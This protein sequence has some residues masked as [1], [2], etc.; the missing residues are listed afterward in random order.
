MTVGDGR[1]GAVARRTRELLPLLPFLTVVVIFLLIP[2]V[3]VVVGSVYADGVFSLQRIEAL[4]SG[5]A[6][7]AL[8]DSVL[9][10]GATALLG[11]VF[12]AVLAWLIVNS[13]ATSMVRRAVLSLCSV[14]AQF[15]GVALAF[16]FLATAGINGVLTLWVQQLFGWN[17]AGSGWLYGLGGLIL[18]YTYF[19]IPLMVIVFIPALEGL[20]AQWREAA[21]SL[22]A[23]TWAYWR[24]V[25][26]P[27]LTPAFLGSAL[28]L[29]AN[30]FAAYATAAALVSQ[31]SPIVPLLIRASLVSEV[32]LGQEG[33]AYALALE[34]IVVV[35]LV[36]GAYN[37]LVR[38]SARWL[39]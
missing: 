6:L 23:S 32:V 17:M 36:M 39:S 31:G 22:G 5:T 29:F 37:L 20:R 1:S 2:T 16:A 30:A 26:I 35:A 9:L 8:A 7:A 19:Q 13:P 38:R 12:G 15:G 10:S 21:V 3:T 4:F 24:E 28:L 33:F 11:A 18:V 14:L 27:L 25:A 34:M